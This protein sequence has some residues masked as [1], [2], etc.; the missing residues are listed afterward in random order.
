MLGGQERQR[1]RRGLHFFIGEG[2][3][4][5]QLGTR[6]F[7]VHQSVVSVV[8]ETEFAGDGMSHTV[9]TGCKRDIIFLNKLAQT[10]DKGD[11]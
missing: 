11:D 2:N 10:K 1:V 8:K 4:S 9:L 3:K 5:H 6:F 7:C